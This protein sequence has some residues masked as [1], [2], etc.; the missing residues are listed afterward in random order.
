MDGVELDDA[1]LRYIDSLNPGK[2]DDMLQ[3]C[4]KLDRLPA[5]DFLII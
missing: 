4:P 2:I 5:N 1:K 3:I